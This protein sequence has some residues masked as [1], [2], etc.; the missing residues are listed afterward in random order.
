LSGDLNYDVLRLP[1][2]SKVIILSNSNEEGEVRDDTATDAVVAPS[3]AEKP[4]TPATSTVT[5]EDPGKMQDDNSDDP[6]PEQDADKG[7]G[8]GD[9]AGLP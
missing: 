6:A 2:D 3:T 8:S 4:S 9:E 5:N 7:S 1:G